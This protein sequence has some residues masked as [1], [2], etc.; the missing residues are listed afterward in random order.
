MKAAPPAEIDLGF[1][2]GPKDQASLGLNQ[3]LPATPAASTD[4]AGVGG[5]GIVRA[6]PRHGA[7]PR[8]PMDRFLHIGRKRDQMD[9]VRRAI[10]ANRRIAEGRAIVLFL[11]ANRQDRIAVIGVLAVNQDAIIARLKPHQAV[12]PDP[13]QRRLKRIA[14][15]RAKRCAGLVLLFLIA[16]DRIVEIMG[17]IIPQRH[18]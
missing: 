18:R 15:R 16:V 2:P 4:K 5:M 14:G 10:A 3:P 9:L 8:R 12:G 1:G 11:I 7:Q 17:K 13:A 6:Q